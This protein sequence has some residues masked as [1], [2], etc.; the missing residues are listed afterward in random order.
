MWRVSAL[1]GMF[2]NFILRLLYGVAFDL[3]WG[4]T[5]WI[6]VLVRVHTCLFEVPREI[7][8][9]GAPHVKSPGDAGCTHLGGA[10][11]VLF[12]RCRSLVLNDPGGGG[13][14]VEVVVLECVESVYNLLFFGLVCVPEGGWFKGTG[15][16][17]SGIRLRKSGVLVLIV[18]SPFSLLKPKCVCGCDS[19]LVAAV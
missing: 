8:F 16:V 4:S 17:V 9:G 5:L 10:S 19:K 6:H 11:R 14:P 7:D 15:P 2:C 3:F 1:W 18:R 12:N 13:C